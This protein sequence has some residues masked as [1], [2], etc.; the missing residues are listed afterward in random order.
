M[1]FTSVSLRILGLI[2]I[3][4]TFCGC[5]QQG[6]RS[7]IVQKVQDSGAGDLSNLPQLNIQEWLVRHKDLAYQV[8]AM[9]KPVQEKAA[10]AWRETTEGKVCGAAHQIALA[11]LVPVQGDSVSHWPGK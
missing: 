3:S 4:L 6:P 5:T 10:A 11:R 8:D 2:V 7:P 9:C 1:A